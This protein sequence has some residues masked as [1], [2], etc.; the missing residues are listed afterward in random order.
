ML[1]GSTVDTIQERYSRQVLYP[2]IGEQG[3]R[4]LAAGH[5]AVVGC[6]ATGAAAAALLAR[7]G[8]G[9]LT[10]IDRDF[11]EESNLQ[12]QVL[13]DEADVRDNLPKAEAARRKIAL[14]N[15]HIQVQAD[16]ADLT[17]ANIHELLAGASL[18]LDATDNFETRY[19]LNDYAVEQRKPW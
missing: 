17:P 8:V 3:Q 14:F 6:G 18:V 1:R 16:V 11:V 13:F 7:A 2:G 15:S 9:T 5:V 19:L 10:L 12:R 4:R